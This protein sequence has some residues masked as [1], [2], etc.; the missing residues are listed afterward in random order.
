MPNARAK[1]FLMGNFEITPLN[2]CATCEN[3]ENIGLNAGPK[4]TR[5][6]DQKYSYKISIYIYMD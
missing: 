2:S 5:M 6:L 1:N 4:I 3:F